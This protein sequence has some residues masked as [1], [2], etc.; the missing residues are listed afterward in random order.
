MDRS[1]FVL[2]DSEGV[3]LMDTVYCSGPWTEVSFSHPNIAFVQN[4]GAKGG[5][6]DQKKIVNV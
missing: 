5:A 1:G 4:C 3:G 6:Q 2:S